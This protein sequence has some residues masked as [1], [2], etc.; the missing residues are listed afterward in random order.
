MGLLNKFVRKPKKSETDFD[1]D[2]D[3]EASKTDFSSMKFETQE[4]VSD[5]E[6][7]ASYLRS[8]QVHEIE[9]LRSNVGKMA[10]ALR[11]SMRL[12]QD[13]VGDIDKISRFLEVAEANTISVERL[14][15]ENTKLKSKLGS[16]RDEIAKADARVR[17]VETRAEMYKSRL[18][19]SFEEL[20]STRARL[21]EV[22]ETFRREK[23]KRSESN[24]SIEKL[25]SERR[26][27]RTVIE[28]LESSRDGMVEKF[29]GL[30]NAEEFRNRKIVQLMK[31]VEHMSAQIED[32]R[33]TKH[34]A[35]SKLRALKLDYSD[36]KS[37]HIEALSKLD[38]SNQEI[39]SYH[40]ILA[41]FKKHSEDKIF[42]LTSALQAQKMQQK[43]STD[44]ARYE[45]AEQA[46]LKTEANRS[47][48]RAREI[49]KILKQ[50]M[51]DLRDNREALANSKADN[52][53]LNEKFLAILVEMDGLR[54]THQRQS[55]KL[56][57]YSTISAVAAG[58]D[59]NEKKSRSR[60]AEQMSGQTIRGDGLVANLQVITEPIKK[61]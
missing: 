32:E 48:R 24:H 18:E 56:G 14:R 39:K 29:E 45:D 59:F 23:G 34:L 10:N 16:V 11:D 28:E 22:E 20:A 52:E 7:S 40:K 6:A 42:A 31:Q 53:A 43:V 50:N 35:V 30:K 27:L 13:A 25:L 58:Q 5:K 55:Q 21:I 37:K 19:L 41:D 9:E 1:I 38:F 36:L 2:S 26:D 4:I 51:A 49:E 47:K 3:I 44:M 57:E 12:N 33:Q 61:S 8:T 46:K 17:E 54:R 15:P 60:P